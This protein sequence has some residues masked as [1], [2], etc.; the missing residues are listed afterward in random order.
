MASW[1]TMARIIS[2]PCKSGRWSDQAAR[3]PRRPAQTS[4]PRAG[5]LFNG[6]PVAMANAIAFESRRCP[7]FFQEPVIMTQANALFDL[8]GKTALITGSSQGIGFALAKGL[9]EAGATVC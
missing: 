2:Y 6:L 1:A 5:L 4:L 8:S 3:C 9:A 7:P